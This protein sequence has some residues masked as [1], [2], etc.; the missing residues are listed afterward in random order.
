VAAVTVVVNPRRG[1]TVTAMDEQRRRPARPIHRNRPLAR[2]DRR[3]VAIWVVTAALLLIGLL[4]TYA[5]VTEFA[6]AVEHGDE[7]AQF[8]SLI[9]LVLGVLWILFAVAL[10]LGARWGKTGALTLCVVVFACA[11]V[12]IL[13][14]SVGAE[15]AAVALAVALGLFFA[16]LGQKTHEWT[17]G[18]SPS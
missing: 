13:I 3:P 8:P 14:E 6:D 18:S 1:L 9:A 15:E 4:F 17:G 11:V 2:P 7:D 10:F 5:G 12:G 16:L